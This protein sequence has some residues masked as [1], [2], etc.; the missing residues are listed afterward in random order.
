MT[1]YLDN[2]IIVSIENGDYSFEKIKALL[3]DP[4]TRFFYSSA[5][6][7]EVENFQGN[8]TTTKSDLLAKRFN[9]VRN[10]F[11]NNYLYFD[12]KGNRLTHIIEDPQEVY[13]TIILVP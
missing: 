5:H 1:A 6:I 10:I 8:S 13:D 11:K 7:F 9:T 4:K 3:P 12:L 2:N